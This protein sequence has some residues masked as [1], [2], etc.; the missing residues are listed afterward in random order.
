M[1]SEL[2]IQG[3]P[4]LEMI[5]EAHTK[6]MNDVARRFRT[7]QEVAQSGRRG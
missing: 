4:A 2:A 1:E 5:Q 6:M 7:M 3:Q